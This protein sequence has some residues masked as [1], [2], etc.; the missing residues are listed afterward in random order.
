MSSK[1]ANKKL[2]PMGT[3]TTEAPKLVSSPKKEET[4]VSVSTESNVE[5]KH[6]VKMVDYKDVI[7]NRFEDVGIKESILKGIYQYGWEKP[8]N[9]QKQAIPAILT[10][11]DVVMQA[12]SGQGKTGAFVVS[13]LQN[14]DENEP[15]VQ[16]I[17]LV[18]VHELAEQIY[19]V[20]QS[21]ADKLEVNVIKCVG[22]THVKD[23]LMYPRRA[24]I[25]VGTPGKMRTVLEK[26]LI[27]SQNFAL[28]NFVIDECDKMLEENFLDDVHAI[29]NHIGENTQVILSSA[30]Y[31]DD[32]MNISSHFMRDPILI[33]I[34][35]ED[36]NLEGIQQY[37]IRLPQESDKYETILDLYNSLVIGQSIIFTSSKKKCDY[38]EDSFNKDSFAVGSMHGGMET[39]QREQT[40]D[41]FRRG[42]IR[43]LLSTDL[44]GR[45]IDIPGIS[46][47]V[48]YDI[49]HDA[50]QYLHR[51]GRSGRYGKKGNAITLISSKR[52]ED[53]LKSIEKEF[54]I[55][56]KELPMDFAN[57]IK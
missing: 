24:T 8:S 12:Q 34:K 40:M 1:S 47:V 2:S 49:P 23:R 42:H 41:N 57:M 32:V 26:R 25:L 4:K 22:G 46:L 9:I 45:G 14:L 28:R 18:H 55:E 38:L 20:V 56:I 53:M 39:A 51:I 5:T 35:E 11:R 6:E 43:I 54:G 30:T 36:L 13:V 31:N 33:I 7:M 3:K 19:K 27:K 16:A 37:Y 50:A 44:T 29:F 10:Q 21:L 17:I 52:D 48:N 15:T